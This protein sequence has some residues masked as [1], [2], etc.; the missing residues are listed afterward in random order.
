MD[1]TPFPE[2][3]APEL[4]RYWL[5]SKFEIDALIARLCDERVPMTVYWGRDGG[6]AVTQIMKVDAVL[7]EVHFDLPSQPLQQS[8]LLD[9]VELVCVAFIESVKLQ[10]AIEA[11]RR[12]SNAGFPTF[13]SAL[14]DRVL[15][16]QRREYYRVR[17]PESLSASCLVPYS[18]DQAQYESLRVLDVSVG[19]LAMLAY[20][21]HFDP[22]AVNVIDRCYLDLPG[23]GT[24]TVRMR[25]AHLATSADGES[26]RC[27]CEFVDLSPQARMM[28]QRYVHKLDVEQR[29]RHGPYKVA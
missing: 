25:V 13:V 7:N 3:A 12:S 20:P 29:H 16:L 21:R 28:L 22:S 2:P 19:G 15:R 26:R 18:G 14:P 17:T 11:P 10:F 5:Y 23:V 24:V 8:Q 9:A 4:E 1:T 27:G 6:F